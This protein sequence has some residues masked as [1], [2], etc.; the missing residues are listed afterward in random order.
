MKGLA[1]TLEQIEPPPF[2]HA[3][4][5]NKLRA[6][7]TPT[8]PRRDLKFQWAAAT[9]A[10]ALITI[11]IALLPPQRPAESTPSWP[12]LET[13]INFKTSLP[14]NPLEAEIKNLREDTLNAAKGLAA[15]FL[16]ASE[17]SN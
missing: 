2:L 7:P 15:T 4:V 3:R 8:S 17:D 13:Q 12:T 16:P 6:T 1:A 9:C 10:V 14:E 11:G 5:M